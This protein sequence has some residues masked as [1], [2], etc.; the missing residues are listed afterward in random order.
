MILYVNL[1]QDV[2][3]DKHKDK[4]SAVSNI[5]VLR[6]NMSSVS[7]PQAGQCHAVHLSDSRMIKILFPY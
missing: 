5:S 4:V 7:Y 6:L 1:T 2:F 3:T